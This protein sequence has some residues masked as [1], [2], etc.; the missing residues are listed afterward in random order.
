[1]SILVTTAFAATAMLSNCSWNSPGRNPYRGSVRDAV[2]R[3]V[4]IPAP[5]RA[6]L[7]ARIEAGQADD[8]VAI[9]RDSIAGKYDYSPQ[10]TDM[11]FGQR[12]VCG[13]VVRDG[14]AD[15][16]REPA[17]V[18]CEG[19]QCLIVPRVCG[20]ISRVR[21][22]VGA[23]GGRAG[24]A[25]ALPAPLEMRPAAAPAPLRV[26][27]PDDVAMADALAQVA[28]GPEMVQLPSA[29]FSSPFGSGSRALDLTGRD[30]GPDSQLTHPAPVPEPATA[31]MLGA[32][33]ALVL[34]MAWRRARRGR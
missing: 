13:T 11:H 8:T 24:A 1:M 32:G 6:R 27:S 7:V 34:G 20:N 33:L 26:A 14:W 23:G 22:I 9:M 12:T 16:V 17:K 5:A 28:A 30:A 3:Y 29:A 19:D 15:T 18:Y 10:I 4:D 2:S 25:A 31:G 21:R